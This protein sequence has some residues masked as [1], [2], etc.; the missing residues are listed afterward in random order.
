MKKRLQEALEH[1]EFCCAVYRWQVERGKYFLHEHPWG[2]RSWNL[3]VIQAIKSLPG[4]Q[5]RCGDQ[6][7]FGQSVPAKGWNNEAGHLL[8]RKRTGWM[9]N[10][11]ELADAVGVRCPNDR[12]PPE[13]R[14]KHVHLV[15]QRA[16]PAEV[17][18]PRL[19]SAILRAVRDRLRK[20]QGVAIHSVE[21][22]IGRMLMR[23][24][25][26]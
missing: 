17:Y 12:L 9:S 19:V 21:F 14:H 20:D 3:K 5:V 22:G 4:V 15:N 16:R 13:L 2:A 7:C 1:L 8:A 24:L 18:P 6:C 25:F 23:T 26:L 10:C 11:V